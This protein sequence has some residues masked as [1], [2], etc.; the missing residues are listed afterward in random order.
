MYHRRLPK[1]VKQGL[2]DPE[3]E[4]DSCGV[5]VVANIRGVKSHDILRK[6][7]QVLVNL[8][9]RGAS[10]S[11]PNTGDGAGVL[12]QMPHQ[13][14]SRECARLG[15]DLPPPGDYGVGMVFFPRDP[16]QRQKCQK[17]FEDI[18]VEEGQLLLGWRDVPV[19]DSRIGRHARGVEPL[20]RQVFVGRGPQTSD[21]GHLVRKLYVIRRRVEKAVEESGIPDVDTFYI[22]SLSSSQIVYKG[23]LM[24]GQIDGFYRDLA[25]SDMLT[26]FAM[27]HSRFSTNTLGSW[28]LAHPYR[29]IA[30]N[31]EINTLR[32]N[33]NWMK[34]R[35]AAFS[36]PLFD[37]DMEK[38]FPIIGAGQSDTACLDNALE[39]LLAT[40]RSL[41]HCMMML[42]PEAWGD[43]ID[44]SPPK[45]D[46]Y[47]YHSCL[48]EPWD[49][50][51]LLAFTDGVRIGAIL[52]RNGLRPFRY[53]V[54]QGRHA[55]D[56]LRGGGAGRTAG[57]RCVQGPAAARTDVPG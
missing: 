29:F 25:D 24:A 17:I 38:L 56:G 54:T 44:M 21:A 36:S 18:V 4:H 32:G 3:D 7:L 33:L 53:L 50:P 30:H 1:L 22:S 15:M 19:D 20:I 37:G 27:V 46:F 43:H 13:F 48:M 5:G 6:A 39:L 9:H 57:G 2:Y 51:A 28:K 47:E 11:D 16:V 8:G 40:G 35:Q 31:G 55:G 12:L 14:F 41:P 26:S 52:D 45:R 34:A 49:G 23:L 10:G 42:I